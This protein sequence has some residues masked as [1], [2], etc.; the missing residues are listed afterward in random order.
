MTSSAVVAAPVEIRTSSP[1]TSSSAPCSAAHASDALAGG[2]EVVARLV[3]RG[4]ER[5]H[6]GD[7]AAVGPRRAEHDG[8][9]AERAGRERDALAE[10]AGTH[11]GD[12]PVRSD[13][14]LPRQGADRD[15]RPA[16]LERADGVGGLDLDDDRRAGA[17]AQA[18]VDV[19]RRVPEGRVDPGVGVADR[20]GSRWGLCSITGP[21]IAPRS[22]RAHRNARR[23]RRSVVDAADLHPRHRF[24]SGAP[25]G[26]TY[27]S[28]PVAPPA[29]GLST[30]FE[31][32][33]SI[34]EAV[35]HSLSTTGRR[36]RRRRARAATPRRPQDRTGSRADR[37][38]TRRARRPDR[39]G[40][41]CRR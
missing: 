29:T 13:P 33:R 9:D 11:A 10:V 39:P 34:R 26:K 27:D 16:A 32:V 36:I 12:R 21:P 3:D 14:P 22:G 1:S 8:R 25:S 20:V 31:E 38:V 7:L 30:S 17:G 24:R 18:V 40:A 4:P 19:L 6:P 23:N 35:V 15:P 41:R 28:R 5:P 37:S 2:V